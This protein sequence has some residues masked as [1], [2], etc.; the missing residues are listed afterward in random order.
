[1]QHKWERLIISVITAVPGVITGFKE[2]EAPEVEKEA[3]SEGY[4]W[5]HG[6]FW[7]TTCAAALGILWLAGYGS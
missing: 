1:M 6:R 7:Y 3:A 5:R 4:Q 2:S